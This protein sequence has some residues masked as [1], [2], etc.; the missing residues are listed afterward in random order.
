MPVYTQR[1]RCS[2]KEP[3]IRGSMAPMRKSGSMV[4]FAV[5]M[6]AP[7]GLSDGTMGPIGKF[8]SRCVLK[9]AFP[10]LDLLEDVQGLGHDLVHI[11]IAVGGQPPAEMHAFGPGHEG[12]VAAEEL[13]VFRSGH[14]VIG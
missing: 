11:V 4:S 8:L 9:G 7:V 2:T 6:K 1:P 5:S 12:V 13:G 10:C 14:R 3:K